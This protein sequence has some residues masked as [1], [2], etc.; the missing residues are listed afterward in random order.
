MFE[1][2]YTLYSKAKLIYF[3]LAIARAISSGSPCDI[4][5][6]YSK[7]ASSAFFA[8]TIFFWLFASSM[9]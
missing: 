9:F 5:F 3:V 4:D 2:V 1:Y 8:A 7:L 6:L